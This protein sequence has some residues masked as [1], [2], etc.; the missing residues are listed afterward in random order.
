MF[1]KKSLSLTAFT[2]SGS[3]LVSI[4]LGLLALIGVVFSHGLP[5]IDLI[6]SVLIGYEA[7]GPGV[8]IGLVWGFLIG[9]LYGYIFSWLYNKMI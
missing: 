3:C 1:E 2:L 7:T 5:L 6:G 9:G 4:H 8:F